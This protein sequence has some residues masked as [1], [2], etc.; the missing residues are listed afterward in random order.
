ML[1]KNFVQTP[2]DLKILPDLV[3]SLPLP[4]Q[5]IL[6]L[7]VPQMLT[8]PQFETVLPRNKGTQLKVQQSKDYYNMTL[9]S[10]SDFLCQVYKI[11]NEK[12]MHWRHLPKKIPCHFK[13]HKWRVIMA[14]SAQTNHI[15]G[16][17]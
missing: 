3:H 9:Y 11:S 8:H 17:Y 7:P 16:L 4:V 5:W 12:Y 2:C 1:V 6:K 15:L 14:L 13:L 10:G